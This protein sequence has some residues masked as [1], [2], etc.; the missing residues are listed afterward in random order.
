MR[1]RVAVDQVSINEML[2]MEPGRVSPIVKDLT[3]VEMPADA[4]AVFVALVDHRHVAHANV[5]E[6][7]A[8]EVTVI[9]A[10]FGAADD[11]HRMMVRP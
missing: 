5:I 8:F 3:A 6:V 1:W 2:D 11:G 9:E 4:P 10:R 7:S